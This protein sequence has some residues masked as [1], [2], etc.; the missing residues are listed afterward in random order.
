M[1]VSAP[2]RRASRLCTRWRSRAGAT[3]VAGQSMERRIAGGGGSTECNWKTNRH[4]GK[5]RV[6]LSERTLIRSARIVPG[7]HDSARCPRDP[8][9]FAT[10]P[11]T[12]RR[13]PFSPGERLPRYPRQNGGGDD[14][15][16][17]LPQGPDRRPCGSGSPRVAC[18]SPPA[19][20]RARQHKA[21]PAFRP[22]L[23]HTESRLP[24]TS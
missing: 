4:A 7:G 6:A 23:S 11:S 24:D 1:D 15:R 17:L 5:G 8:L 14:P 9:T 13:N 22:A 12:T 10:N 16:S 19:A 21:V 2:G 18:G 3:S 20:A